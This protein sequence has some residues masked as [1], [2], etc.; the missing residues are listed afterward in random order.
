M[1]ESVVEWMTAKVEQYELADKNVLEVGSRYVNGTNRDLFTGPYW[2][3]DL[4]AGDCVDWVWN[5][6]QE[7]VLTDYYGR[8]FDVVVCTEMLEHTPFPGKA[9]ANIA[10]SLSPGGKLLLTTRSP[11]FAVHDEPDYWRYTAKDLDTLLHFS[12]LAIWE[13]TPDPQAPGVFILA[14]KAPEPE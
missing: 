14:V 3:I 2:G 10:L 9:L 11:G 8:P 5:I 13:S 6:E 12:G 7:P 1:H 4:R